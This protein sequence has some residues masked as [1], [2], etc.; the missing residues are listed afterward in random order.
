MPAVTLSEITAYLD[1]YLRTR[2]TPDDRNAVNGLQV[3]NSGTVGSIV[4]AVDASQTT[5]DG[6]VAADTAAPALLMV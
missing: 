1:E 3:E 5:I 6:V 4:A 2:E